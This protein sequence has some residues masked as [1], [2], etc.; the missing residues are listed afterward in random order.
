MKKKMGL[1]NKKIFLTGGSGFIGTALCERLARDNQ[2]VIYDS[3]HRNA[4]KYT[5]LLKQPNFRFIKGNILDKGKLKQALRKADIIIHLAA[6]AGI[7]SV[8][9]SPLET[10]KVNL[11]G[12]YNILEALKNHSLERFIYFSTSEVYGPY[13]FRADEE[14][15]TTQGSVSVLRWNYSVS[16]LAGEHLAYSYF[17]ERGLPLVVVRPFNIYGPRQIGEGAVHKFVVNAIQ[18]RDL[19]IYGDGT[20]IR[21]WCYIDDLVDAVLKTLVEAKAVGSIINIGNPNGTITVLG[22]AEKIIE[23]SQ[24]K[25]KI[26]FKKRNYPDV[27]LRVPNIEKARKLLGHI[28]KS[29]LDEG[30]KRTIEWYRSCKESK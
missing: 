9:V 1:K 3:G 13:V 7:D 2:I 23:L 17:T 20:Q 16:K 22:L 25:S 8:G 28:P 21:A 30:L 4:L 15:K 10:M 19:I 18:N 29:G 27:E 14:R 6:I 24:S 11:I 5:D 12:T 26:V